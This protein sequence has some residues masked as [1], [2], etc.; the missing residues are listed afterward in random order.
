[1]E[2]R[3]VGAQTSLQPLALG[4]QLP[5]IGHLRIEQV[6]YT[7]IARRLGD[8]SDTGLIESTAAE[9]AAPATVHCQIVGRLVPQRSLGLSLTEGVLAHRTVEGGRIRQELR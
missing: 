6:V 4:A 9:A 3:Q 2:Q 7:E 1:M 5:G 8:R